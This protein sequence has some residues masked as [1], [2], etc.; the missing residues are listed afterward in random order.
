MPPRTADALPEEWQLWTF[1]TRFLR[2]SNASCDQNPMRNFR[3]GYRAWLEGALAE[4]VPDEVVA[5][6]FNL[7]EQNSH[8]GRYGVEL[9][10]VSEFDPG[11]PDWACAEA[12]EP[13]EGRESTIPSSFCD[14]GW[15]EFL[16]EMSK[17][18]SSFL[19]EPSS[20]AEKLNSV[21]GIGIG[22]VDGELLLLKS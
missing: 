17:L 20:L 1:E 2:I 3:D 9:V 21:R 10:G 4:G 12:W 6:V 15:V 18:I 13:S 14:G 8:D 19:M 16:T 5:F 7:F 22:F 11:N